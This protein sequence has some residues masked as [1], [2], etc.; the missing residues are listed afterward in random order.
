MSDI[1]AAYG[2]A[3]AITITLTSLG[4]GSARQST[5]IDNSTDLFRDVIVRIKTLGL[6]GSVNELSVYLY[7][8][9]GDTVRSGGAGASDAAFTGQLEELAF[10]GTVQMNGTTSVTA[11]MASFL[12][13][14]GY[15]PNKWGIVVQNDSGA[16]LSAT[17]GDHD[18]DHMGIFDTVA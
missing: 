5:E 2:A 3:T 6:A 13:A 12:Q 14:L 17:G 16:A 18:V 10:L 11:L 8:S 9:V 7:G 15:V 4:D 1:K